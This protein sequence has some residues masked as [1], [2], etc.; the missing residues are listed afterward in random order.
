MNEPAR[1]SADGPLRHWELHVEDCGDRVRITAAGELDLA[2]ASQLD[3]ALTE[4]EGVARRVEVDLR[5]LTFMDSSGIN[6]LMRH[7]GRARGD[8]TLVIVPPPPRVARVL[9]VAGVTDLLPLVDGS[10]GA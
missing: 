1:L 8:L 2:T 6:L 3:A 7:A 9:D 4:A 10:D 5:A